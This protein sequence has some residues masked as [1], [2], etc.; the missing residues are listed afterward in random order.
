MGDVHPGRHV[1]PTASTFPA[2]LVHVGLESFQA[3]RMGDPP[4]VSLAARL[5]ELKLPV[6]RLK[7]GTPPRIDG[8]TIDF[9]QTQVQPGDDPAPVFSF[10][11]SSSRMRRMC[12]AADSVERI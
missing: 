5:R 9:G 8:R 7:T 3:G 11:D 12:S 2:G 1:Q 6:G 10:I 4:A